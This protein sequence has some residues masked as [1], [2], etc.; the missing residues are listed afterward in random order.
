MWITTIRW[1][2]FA[3]VL[4]IEAGAFLMGEYR[5][6]V[7]GMIFCFFLTVHQQKVREKFGQP[8]PLIY[9]VFLIAFLVASWLDMSII[10]PMEL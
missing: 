3:L 10:S 5:T 4:I 7:A 1:L 6:W 8:Y 2:T 9:L